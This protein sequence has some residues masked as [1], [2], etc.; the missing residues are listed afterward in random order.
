MLYQAHL[1]STLPKV[2]PVLGTSN[3]S[4]IHLFVFLKLDQSSQSPVFTWELW[5]RFDCR[6]PDSLVLLPPP[7]SL[8][9]C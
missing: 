3:A 6:N 1:N 9:E 7:P 8:S 4:E 2:Q 5:A